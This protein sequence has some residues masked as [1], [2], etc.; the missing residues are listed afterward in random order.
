ML[1]HCLPD[2][3]VSDL[4]I[5]CHLIFV[6]LSVMCLYFSV[7]LKFSVYHW[8]SVVMWYSAVFYMFLVL[9]VC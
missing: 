3:I 8:F 2:C 1:F 4:E 9:G 6:F 7:L 5:H